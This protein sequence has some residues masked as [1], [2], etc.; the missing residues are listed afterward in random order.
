[1]NKS[2][3]IRWKQRFQNF[4]KSFL[5]LKRTL[6]IKKP[7]E[8]ERGGLIQ[9]YEMTFELAWKLLRDYLYEQGFNVNSPREA[10][11]QAYQSEIIENGQDWI[12]ALEDRNL[13]THTY[14]EETALK[15]VKA[16]KG[17]YF[18]LL[19][20]LYTRVKREI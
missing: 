16:I 7:S 8:A 18:P 5:L 9:F 20:A 12:D 1:M 13:T 19:N 15:V 17:S 3:D 10:I 14:D 11:K 2:K 6:D 4:E